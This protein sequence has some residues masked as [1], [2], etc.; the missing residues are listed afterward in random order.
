[1]V[2]QREN[3]LLRERVR[4]FLLD[5]FDFGSD[6]LVH[7]A[8]RFLVDVS[9]RVLEGVLADPHR[10][11]EVVPFEILFRLGDRIVVFDFL[12]RHGFCGF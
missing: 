8:R 12:R 3:L 11:G 5:A 9:E 7:L 2:E 6:A 4:V 1:M 10:C